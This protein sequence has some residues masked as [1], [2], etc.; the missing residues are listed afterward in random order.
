MEAVNSNQPRN[1]GFIRGSIAAGAMMGAGK[2]AASTLVFPMQK[3]GVVNSSDKATLRTIAQDVLEKTKLAQK[4]VSVVEVK[5]ACQKNS[6]SFKEFLQKVFDVSQDKTAV[7]TV[8][9]ELL[10]NKNNKKANI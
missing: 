10:S 5:E 6:H 3:A 2:L 1:K 4:G 8:Q 9:K 7:K